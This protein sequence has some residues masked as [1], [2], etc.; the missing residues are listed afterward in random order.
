MSEQPPDQPEP[1]KSS[2][3]PNASGGAN[4]QAGG[5]INVGGDVVGRDKVT[6]TTTVTNVGMTPEAVRR[7]VITVGGLVFV[8]AFCFFAFGAV[9]AAA[10]LNAF[11]RPLPSTPEAAQDFQQKL[12]VIDALPRGQAFEWSF[13]ENDLSSYLR[14][15]LGPQIGFDGRAR[16]LSSQQT[17]F[18]GPWVGVN[19]LPVMVVTTMQ[20]NSAELYHTDRAY[21]QIL[22]LGDNLGWVPVPASTVQPLIDQINHDIGSGFVA[23]S[24]RYPAFTPEGVPVG[25]LTLQGV[26]R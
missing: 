2:P 9:T 1:R 4:V 10:A 23:T 12:Q 15:I 3:L 7:L 16:F 25:S 18:K 5:D 13:E 8:T 26:A 11:A 14:F 24:V 17:S 22:P 20:T 19:N 21:V 6:Q